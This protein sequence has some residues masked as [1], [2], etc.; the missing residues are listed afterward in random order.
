MKGIVFNLLEEMVVSKTDMQ[1]W[2]VI[3]QELELDGIYT[4]GESYPDEELMALVDCI[5]QK[6]QIP[7]ET[8]IR[9][10]GGELFKGLVARY[11][12][13]VDSQAALFDFLKSVHDVIHVEVKKLYDNPHLPSFEYT[14]TDDGLIMHYRSPRK[15]C[16][17][18][19]GL[20]AGA[21]LHYDT[22]IKIEHTTCMLNGCDHCDIHVRLA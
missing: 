15:L 14:E 21:A 5:S 4:S 10:F 18:A 13:F 16:T 6:T 22:A 7:K 11:P 9:A 17:L 3:L 19:E 12:I 20:I 1:T 2:N 8:L